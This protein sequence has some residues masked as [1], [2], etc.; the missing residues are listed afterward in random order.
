MSTQYQIVISAVEKGVKQTLSALQSGFK[1]G[2][3][4]VRVFN[5]ASGKGQQVLAGL[6]GQVKNLVAAYLSFRSL[7]EVNRIMQ[8]SSARLRKLR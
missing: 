1:T 8:E 2:T 3:D 5:E 4:A 6:G 7:S